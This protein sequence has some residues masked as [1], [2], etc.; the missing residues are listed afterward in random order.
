M[1]DTD[2]RT[3]LTRATGDLSTPPDLLDRVRAGGRRRVV[4]RRALLGAGLAT[5]AAG[6]AAGVLL[7][8]GGDDGDTQV[9]SP[10]LDGDTRGDL[11]GDAAFLAQARAVWA[12]H[13]G[14]IRVRGEPHVIWAGRAPHAG[15]AAVIAQR[16]PQRVA[17]PA[18][19]ISYG[20]IGFLEQT[21]AGLRA[22]SLE[23]MLT[24]AVNAPAVLLA[25]RHDVLMVLDDGRGVRYSPRFGYDPDGTITRTFTPLD[26]RAHD[27][28]AF[29]ATATQR[30][31]IQIALRAD[32][33][34]TRGDRTVGLAN[35]SALMS[36]Q[37]PP[38]AGSRLTRPLPG[39]E[40][41][42][43]RDAAAEQ[44]AARWDLAGQD[45]F[46]DRYGYRLQPP[47]ATW[48]IRGATVDRRRFVVQTLTATDGRS[49]VY[50]SLGTPAPLLKGFADPGAPLPVRVRLP[51]D[52]GVV[53]ASEGARLRYRTRAAGWLPVTGDAALL[54]ATAT[55]VEVHRPGTAEPVVA[56]LA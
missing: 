36:G 17:S 46:N 12:G 3:A 49:R 45:E 39:R 38:N 37:T 50:L 16:V 5:V 11:R 20:L 8:G 40:R 41:A 14:G 2:I 9:A 52:R 55:Q 21:T 7:R 53:V 54:P 19:Q 48:F 13:L 32:R 34:D 43:P 47:P 22:I 56:H 42:W 51:G 35:Q 26:F 10:L 29:A 24:G 23:E 25:P 30:G 15:R 28:V 44:E 1:T 27:G 4:R 18:G 33:A 31:S 6:S